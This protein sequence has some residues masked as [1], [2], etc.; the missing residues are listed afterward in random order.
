MSRPFGEVIH[1]LSVEGK[2]VQAGVFDEREVRAAAGLTLVLGALAFAHAYFAQEYVPL[3]L[4]TT[5]FFIE[6]LLR[7]SLGLR[8][9][10]IGQLARL[11]TAGRAPQWVSAKPK[12]FAWSLGLVMSLAMVVISNLDIR[13]ALPLTVCLICMTLM[14][15]EAALGLCLGCEIHGALVRHGWVAKDEA[16]EVCSH[17]ACNVDAAGQ[18]PRR[19]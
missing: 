9:S 19:P 18:A 6:F 5:L 13:G 14:W 10:P 3:K 11:M 4:V 15:L 17:G 16:Y 7:V 12:R 8:F 2:P 1:G